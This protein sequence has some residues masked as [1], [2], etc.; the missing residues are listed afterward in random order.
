MKSLPGLPLTHLLHAQPSPDPP[1]H[2]LQ[3]ALAVGHPEVV[4]PSSQEPVELLYLLFHAHAVVSRSEL[5]HTI[6][7]ALDALG[8]NR[9]VFR[10]DDKAQKGHTPVYVRDV[11]LLAV[12]REFQILFEDL[13]RDVPV[14]FSLPGIPRKDQDVGA[15]PKGR[16]LVSFSSRLGL[17]TGKI[18]L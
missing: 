15:V 3:K 6:F 14:P 10:V 5:P 4:D 16:P 2:L 7:E 12:H 17:E 1:H 18:R 11:R 8:M 9:Y 13:H